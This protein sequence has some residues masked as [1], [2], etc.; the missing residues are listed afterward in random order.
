MTSKLET[1]LSKELYT[2]FGHLHIKQNYRPEWL[3]G[4]NGTR[5]ELDFYIEEL[6]IAAEVQGN[7]HYFFVEF[8]HKTFDKFRDQRKRDEDKQI[9]CRTRGIKLY[10]ILTEKDADILVKDIQNLTKIEVPVKPQKGATEILKH[11]QLMKIK[12]HLEDSKRLVI[13]ALSARDFRL[14][15]REYPRMKSH[16]K[17]LI[18]YPDYIDNQTIG[19]LDELQKQCR[20]A[21]DER[22]NDKEAM[23]EVRKINARRKR[24]AN[25]KKPKPVTYRTRMIQS[26][27]F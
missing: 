27:D 26:R 20:D 22:R 16:V 10:E 17:T 6:S 8:F 4:T 1:Y 24:N 9:V 13:E 3:T 5:L 15:E 2:R 25:K 18:K 14:L 12:Y 19:E 7:Q 23:K 21:F 11:D